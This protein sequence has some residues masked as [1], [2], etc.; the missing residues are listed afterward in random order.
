VI[1]RLDEHDGH[2]LEQITV[3]RATCGE[4]HGLCIHEG[5]LYYGDAG[6]DGRGKPTD[7]VNGG[8]IVRID[9]TT[10]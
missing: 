3:P 6:I 8:H 5:H 9:N 2:V 10:P 7:S 4:V 1:Q